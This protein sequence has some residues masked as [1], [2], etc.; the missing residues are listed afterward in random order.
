MSTTD[1]RATSPGATAPHG[2]LNRY[3][4]GF[5][6]CEP[7]TTAHARYEKRRK[8]ET[9]N[10]RPYTV[11]AVG[12]Q[13][14]VRALSAIGWPQAEVAQRL[15]IARGNLAAKMRLN[16]SVLRGTHEAMVA[17]YD[18][19][20][21]QIP[22]DTYVA[23]RARA[24]AVKHKWAPPLAWDDIDDPAE[25]PKYGRRRNGSTSAHRT[26]VDDVVVDRVMAGEQLPM[27]PAERGEV[28][29]RLR[30][31]GLSYREIETL[32]GIVKVERHIRR[33]DRAEGEAA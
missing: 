9:H 8:W 27:T 15:G 3:V 18:D 28:V 24:Y 13:R 23:R 33:A 30:A 11:S 14:R 1:P 26:Q 16:A 4:N 6:R 19:L 12:F 17:I 20:S 21:M 2:S 32:T 29:R 31:R 7:C 10:G 5:C 25:R 22:P